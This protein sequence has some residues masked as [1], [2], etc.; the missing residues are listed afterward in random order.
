M[1]MHAQRYRVKIKTWLPLG[2]TT[3]KVKQ[4]LCVLLI[5]YVQCFFFRSRPEKANTDK[6]EEL[7][8]L[9]PICLGHTF[10]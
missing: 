9:I 7:E 8:Y 6:D 5:L 10:S 4:D 2:W 3:R 1:M